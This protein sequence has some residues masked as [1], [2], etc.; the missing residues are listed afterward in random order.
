[1][2]TMHTDGLAV[3]RTDFVIAADLLQKRQATPPLRIRCGLEQTTRS[4]NTHRL[5]IV[6]IAIG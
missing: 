2:I 1:M 5:K 3:L 6:D 4:T